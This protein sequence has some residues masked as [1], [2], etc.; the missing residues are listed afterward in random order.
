MWWNLKTNK[1]TKEINHESRTIE[2][3]EGTSRS[4]KMYK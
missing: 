3:E 4:K 1:Q 2:K